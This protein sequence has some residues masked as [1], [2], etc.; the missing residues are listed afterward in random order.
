LMG[1]Y[2]TLFR[3]AS[4]LSSITCVKDLLP[5]LAKQEQLYYKKTFNSEEVFSYLKKNRKKLPPFRFDCGREDSLYK[6]N[7]MLHQR[8][9]I[10]GIPHTFEEFSGGHSNE[11]WNKNIG[12]TL[13][14]F[15]KLARKS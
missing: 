6:S 9:E 10:E 5:F 11:Y 3:G 8:L 7:V 14:Y 4:G 1:K 12:K 13:I 15:S 2:P